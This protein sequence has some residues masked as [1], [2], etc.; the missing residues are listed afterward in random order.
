M[1]IQRRPKPFCFLCTLSTPVHCNTRKFDRT[2]EVNAEV[3]LNRKESPAS[4]SSSFRELKLGWPRVQLPL[5]LEVGGCLTGQRQPVRQ[6]SP[7]APY[8]EIPS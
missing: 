2:A 8:V 5:E 6:G 1:A 4:R 3:K 7:T